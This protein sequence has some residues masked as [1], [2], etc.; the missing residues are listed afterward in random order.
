MINIQI[1][2]HT[3]LL[4]SKKCI[5]NIYLLLSTYEV[6]LFNKLVYIGIKISFK[7]KMKKKSSR[8]VNN[9]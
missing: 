7:M 5:K 8:N 2:H 4:T 9:S 3:I 1:L 6:W